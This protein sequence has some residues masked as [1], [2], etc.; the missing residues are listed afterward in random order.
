MERWIP[1]YKYGLDR[2]AWPVVVASIV[3]FSQSGDIVASV[4]V[5]KINYNGVGVG[6]LATRQTVKSSAIRLDSCHTG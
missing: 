6:A 3:F 4:V 5:S 2:A 1:T